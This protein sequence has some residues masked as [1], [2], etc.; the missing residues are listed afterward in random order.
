MDPLR[1]LAMTGSTL[2]ARA[3]IPAH[4]NIR[5]QAALH[6][7]AVDGVDLLKHANQEPRMDQPPELAPHLGPIIILIARLQAA[8]VTCMRC[9]AAPRD[10]TRRATGAT[11]VTS[12]VVLCLTAALLLLG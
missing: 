8:H 9:T 7:R 2:R 1:E 11:V 6:S 10:T 5:A 4:R 12:A 3:P